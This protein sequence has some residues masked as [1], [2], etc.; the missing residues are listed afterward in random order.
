VVAPF[1]TRPNETVLDRAKLGL[2]P[3]TESVSGLYAL[4][5]ANGKG[6]GTV[7]LQG[8][9]ATYAFLEEAYP[10]L[11]EKGVDL[12]IY[13][14]SSAE[15]FDLLPRAEQERLFPADHAKEAMGI[16]GF[17]LPTMY[18]W[19]RS[20]D[21]LARTMYP[22]Q[23]GRFLG[24]GQAAMVLREAGMDGESQFKAVMEYVQAKK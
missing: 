12:N 21:G 14:V 18:K 16:T 9:G 13:H 23:K 3:A 11:R 17:T 10:R 2:A 8:S 6:E 22:F 19:I 5:R 1:V 7:V 4:R 24:S 20:E 15:L